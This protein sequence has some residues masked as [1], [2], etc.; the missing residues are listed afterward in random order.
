MG[1]CLFIGSDRKDKIMAIKEDLCKI[2]NIKAGF[3][4]ED[5][6]IAYEE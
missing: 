3:D 1:D 5:N 4:N 6:F 2:P